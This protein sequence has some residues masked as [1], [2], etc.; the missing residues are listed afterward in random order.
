VPEENIERAKQV[1]AAVADRDLDG[2]ISL[3]DP[4][5]QWQSFFAELGV[6]GVYSGHDGIQKYVADLHEAWE[7]VRP[8]VDSALWVG[9]IAVLVGR[10]HYRGKGS[11]VESDAPAGWI[12]RFR[13][14]KLVLFRAFRDPDTALESVGMPG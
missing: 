2:L 11:G 4:D 1:M 12:F 6:G 14:G 13:G 5:V 7:I 10:V 3:T 9:D 8:D